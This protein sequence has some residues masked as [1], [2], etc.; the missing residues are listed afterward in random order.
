MTDAEETRAELDMRALQI[1]EEW[2]G[3]PYRHQASCKGAGTD[4]LGLIRGIWRELYGFEPAKPPAY[5]ANWADLDGGEALLAA[6]QRYLRPCPYLNPNPG[7][8]LL[9]RPYPGGPVKHAGIM[10][11][12]QRFVHAYW[13]RAVTQSYL[14]RWWQRRL[15]AIF[16][17]PVFPAQN[18]HQKEKKEVAWHV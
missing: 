11:C 6:A 8:V 18:L 3:T 5:S 16:A 17:F 13:D 12:D 14:G 2:L 15:A 4:C 1:A 7:H 10:A 9:F